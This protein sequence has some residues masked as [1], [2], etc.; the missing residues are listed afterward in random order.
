MGICTDD[1][2]RFWEKFLSVLFGYCS[3]QEKNWAWHLMSVCQKL[4]IVCMYIHRVI[5]SSDTVLKDGG[6]INWNW[7]CMESFSPPDMAPFLELWHVFMVISVCTVI[8]WF[9]FHA[10]R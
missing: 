4:C 7:K 8:I 10:E 1:M 5:Q 2:L 3:V 6:E 9:S